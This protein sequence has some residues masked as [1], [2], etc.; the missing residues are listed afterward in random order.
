VTRPAGHTGSARNVV[1]S[2]RWSTRTRAKHAGQPFPLTRQGAGLRN[3]R[4]RS[5]WR[6]SHMPEPAW[7]MPAKR[8]QVEVQLPSLTTGRSGMLGCCIYQHRGC[9]ALPGREPSMFAEGNQVSQRA[10]CGW[11]CQ[12]LSSCWSI[13]IPD[14]LAGGRLIAAWYGG[15]A[16]MAAVRGRPVSA[17]SWTRR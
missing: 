8:S 4:S 15:G 12:C 6:V 7:G 1:G 14:K 2:T 5:W 3:R 17:A 11:C 16:E 13:V 9:A 10:S